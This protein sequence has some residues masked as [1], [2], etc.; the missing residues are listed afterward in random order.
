MSHSFAS[1]KFAVGKRVLIMTLLF[2]I[3]MPIRISADVIVQ[4][5]SERIILGNGMNN[6]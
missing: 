1:S 5:F 2:S 4:I 3:R 6:L